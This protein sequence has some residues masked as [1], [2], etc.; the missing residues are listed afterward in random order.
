[1][2]AGNFNND[3]NPHQ[4][5]VTIDVPRGEKSV[6]PEITLVPGR[7]QS[8]HVMGPDG[9]PVSGNRTLSHQNG[10]TAQESEF[11]FVHRNPGKAETVVIIQEKLGLGA[12]V[13]IKGD[14]PDPIRVELRPSGAIVGRLVDED[15][16]PRASVSLQLE[17]ELK[18]KGET[19]GLDAP[20]DR[21]ASG[22][23]GRFRI[24]HIVA[25]VRCVVEVLNKNPTSYENTF[26]GYLK[27]STLKPG[28]VQDWGD[29]RARR[30]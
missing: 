4:A 27:N 26:E 11:P 21:L 30:D 14:E 13:D 8:V 10:E 23:D 24:D 29:V 3:M 1:M 9:R 28:E 19:V 2:W 12:I 16:R 5:I 15:G 20:A 22:P 17:Y 18:T 7:R 25:G 6:I